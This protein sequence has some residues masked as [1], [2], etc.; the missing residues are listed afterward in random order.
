M[1]M[2]SGIATVEQD[3]VETF[4]TV[5]TDQFKERMSTS[6]FPEEKTAVNWDYVN[7]TAID[8]AD[9]K[10]LTKPSYGDMDWSETLNQPEIDPKLVKNN[11]AIS[12]DPNTDIDDMGVL[13]DY[14]ETRQMFDDPENI[15]D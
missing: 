4:D 15:E 11:L 5:D 6:A 7:N 1:E 9:R 2:Q 3:D 8:P 14:D 13:A 12:D 10:N